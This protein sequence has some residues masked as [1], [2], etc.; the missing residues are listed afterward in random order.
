MWLVALAAAGAVGYGIQLGLVQ[1]QS[2]IGDWVSDW[3]LRGV[4]GDP[5][6]STT[7]LGAVG[8]LKQFDTIVMR[9]Y[10][11]PSQAARLKLLHRASFNTLNGTT[12]IARNAPMSGLDP[13][14]D[15]ATWV[16]APGTPDWSARLVARLESGKALL[17][18]PAVARLSS[19]KRRWSSP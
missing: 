4:A 6:R 3:H 19:A 10:A 12:W 11:P 13:E 14:P 16:L 5:Y 2:A 1:A 18:L 17:A 15:G 7:D 9:V 8:R